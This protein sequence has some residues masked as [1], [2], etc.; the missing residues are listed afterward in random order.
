MSLFFWLV[1]ALST[2]G[3]FLNVK[4]IRFCFI[5]WAITNTIWIIHNYNIKEYA[6]SF[7]YVVALGSA[8]WGFIAWRHKNDNK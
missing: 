3:M 5:I 1:T 4:K 7:S 2:L 6:Q 8:I